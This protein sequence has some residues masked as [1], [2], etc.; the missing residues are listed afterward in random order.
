MGTREVLGQEGGGHRA[1]I[2]GS[3]EL[4][5]AEA[6]HTQSPHLRI[7]GAD[8]LRMLSPWAEA[9]QDTDTHTQTHT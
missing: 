9:G 5:W 6:G 4:T 3:A 2:S 7:S 8:R 1:H